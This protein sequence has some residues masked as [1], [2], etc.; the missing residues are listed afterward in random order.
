[1]ITCS[2]MAFYR[3]TGLSTDTKPV[4]GVKEASIFIEEDTL[5]E[6]EFRGD[7]WIMTSDM[8][9]ARISDLDITTPTKYFGYIDSS[10]RWYILRLQGT[11]ARYAA[12]RSGYAV[13]WG[14]RTTLTYKHYGEI[15]PQ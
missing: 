5:R 4:E 2:V 15:F 10:G 14:V 7:T 1:M 11:T 9:N 3:Y 8:P 12:G 13:A 6:F